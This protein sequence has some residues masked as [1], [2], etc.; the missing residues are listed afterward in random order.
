MK[1]LTVSG[2]DSFRSRLGPRKQNPQLL[3]STVGHTLGALETQLCRCLLLACVV[4]DKACALELDDAD[5]FDKP[6]Q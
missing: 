2:S 1:F 5:L 6:I 4:Q 3:S